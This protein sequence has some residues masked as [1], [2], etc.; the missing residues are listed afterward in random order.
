[1]DKQYYKLI[2]KLGEKEMFYVNFVGTSI[3]KQKNFSDFPGDYEMRYT[4]SGFLTI[5]MP[6]DSIV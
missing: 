2:Y 1:M 5:S 6:K 3:G 4:Y